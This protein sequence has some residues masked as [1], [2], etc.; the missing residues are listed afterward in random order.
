M[1][2][3]YKIVETEGCTA[4]AVTINGKNIEDYSEEETIEIM[5]YIFNKLKE[6]VKDGSTPFIDMVRAYL[7]FGSY[8]YDP[9]PC[10]QCGDTVSTTT[11]EV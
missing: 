10:E 9:V 5:D 1:N 3:K 11:W 6:K 8:E 4:F 7:S 2:T